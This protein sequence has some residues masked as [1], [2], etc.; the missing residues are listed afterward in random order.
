MLIKDMH[1][2]GIEISR[3]V[4]KIKLFLLIKYIYKP[5]M[6]HSKEKCA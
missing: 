6:V 4:K 1:K 5:L 2:A 3:S